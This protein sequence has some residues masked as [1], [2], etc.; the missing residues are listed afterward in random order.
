MGEQYRATLQIESRADGETF[1]QTVEGVLYKKPNGWYIRYEELD[2]EG[3]ATRTIVKLT[4]DEWVVKRSGAVDSEMRFAKDRHLAGYYRSGGIELR[5]TTKL[6]SSQLVIE[7]DSGVI[8]WE[9][10]LHIGDS[11]ALIHA[12]TYHLTRH[13]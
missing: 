6:T 9:Y 7:R 11:Q 3:H 4:G 1:E 5:V 12:I 2:D 8:S 10:E 13:T